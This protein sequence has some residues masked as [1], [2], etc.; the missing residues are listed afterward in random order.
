MTRLI[1]DRANP[2]SLYELLDSLAHDLVRSFE[3]VAS[4]FLRSALQGNFDHG[5]KG[6]FSTSVDTD[7]LIEF[8]LAHADFYPREKKA[9]LVPSNHGNRLEYEL[10]ELVFIEGNLT[11]ETGPTPCHGRHPVLRKTL[12]RW[13]RTFDL[14]SEE[15]IKNQS[16]A[17]WPNQPDPDEPEAR[18]ALIPAHVYDQDK[19][20]AFMS[21]LFINK[22]DFARWVVDTFNER[23]LILDRIGANPDLS[24]S[25]K[26]AALER[27]PEARGKAIEDGVPEEIIEAAD[28]VD[29]RQAERQP[30]IDQLALALK[31]FFDNAGPRHKIFNQ[32]AL[33]RY[34]WAAHCPHLKGAQAPRAW[35][36]SAIKL[37]RGQKAP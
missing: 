30:K 3:D 5:P 14:L 29:Y 6:G 7:L 18:C 34:I 9:C 2:H 4:T 27:A 28:T 36:T 25:R 35:L 21:R 17:R 32:S 13:M 19:L 33:A 8:N 24:W 26:L 11:K 31:P 23:P 10:K 16:K 22:H 15:Q 37:I 20:K 1:R 12:L